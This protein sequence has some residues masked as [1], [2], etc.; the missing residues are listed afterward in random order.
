MTTKT[1][2]TGFDEPFSS[3][4]HFQRYPE[5]YPWVGQ[6]FHSQSSRI[7]VV[8]ESHYLEPDSDYHHDATAWYAGISLHGKHDRAWTITRHI[9]A[10]GFESRWKERSKTIYR[11]IEA[12]A[13]DAGVGAS[14]LD[15]PFHSMALMNYF[16]RPAQV[17]GKSI[18]VSA[19]DRAHSAAVLN[20][21]LEILSPQIVIFCSVLVW[22]AAR[23]SIHR[24]QHVRFAF[25][26]HPATRWWHTPMRKYKGKSG[27]QIFIAA[28]QVDKGICDL[29]F[30]GRVG[31]PH[32]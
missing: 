1:W 25:T 15:S 9:I 6:A 22:R 7:L 30:A 2:S 31:L 12:A 28:L 10:N 29:T 3:I 11:N 4:S 20:S 21:V 16:Q 17:S 18:F 19:L 8:G 5:L 27:R 26:P 23:D 13:G 32:R 14:R 24:P